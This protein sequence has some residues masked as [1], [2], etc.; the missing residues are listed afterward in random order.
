MV[1]IK[2]F[3]AV[4]YNPA[5]TMGAMLEADLFCFLGLAYVAF[6]SLVSMTFFWFFEVQPGWEWLADFF[7]L[8][9]IGLAMSIVVWMKVW[10]AK[11]TFNT[12][13]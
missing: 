1:L 8:F 11:P 3:R 6:V 4:Y 9:W 12:G 10:L 2:P 5:K 13:E 7:V